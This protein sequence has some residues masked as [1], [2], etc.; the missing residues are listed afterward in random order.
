MN[1]CMPPL[2]PMGGTQPAAW[3]QSLQDQPLPAGPFYTICSIKTGSKSCVVLYGCYPL[4]PPTFPSPFDQT[5]C[6]VLKSSSPSPLN[7]Q[8]H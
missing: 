8:T 3:Q 4:P 7:F 1:V 5:S 2:A 6:K